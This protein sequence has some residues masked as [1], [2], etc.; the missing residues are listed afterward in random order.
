[1]RLESQLSLKK[2]VSHPCSGQKK[3][4]EKGES[5]KTE[6]R[7]DSCPCLQITPM[8]LNCGSEVSRHRKS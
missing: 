6:M 7:S 4:T 3:G 2:H 5:L 1:M 8:D